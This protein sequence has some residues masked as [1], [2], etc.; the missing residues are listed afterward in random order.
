MTLSFSG[1]P[2]WWGIAG[3]RSLRQLV[4]LYPQLGNRRRR[5]P[6]LPL[7]YFLFMQSR[8]TAHGM[9]SPTVSF[10]SLVEHFW[11]ELQRY[12]QKCVSMVNLTHIRLAMKISIT[13]ASSS[14]C[15]HHPSEDV[16]PWPKDQAVPF[17]QEM[18]SLLKIR[19]MCILNF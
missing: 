12:T 11:K 2:S 16:W 14:P 4:I 10:P 17:F 7:F 3:C 15:L 18:V 8:T 1:N 9:M 5:M 6:M 13:A 19:N